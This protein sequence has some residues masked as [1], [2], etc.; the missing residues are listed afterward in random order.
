M[1]VYVI[2]PF[3][4]GL[5]VMGLVLTLGLTM[6]SQ[7]IFKSLPT[8]APGPI[9]G[10]QTNER[11]MALT[12]NV[13]WGGEVIPGML[14]VLKKEN[15]K[16]TFFVSGR[17]AKNNPELLKTMAAEGHQIEN[18]GYSHPHP[19]RISVDE[20]KREI[21][22]T[23]QVIEGLTGKKTTFFAPPYGEKGA[24][25]LRAANELKYITTLWTLDTVDWR[26]DSTVEL[27]VQRVVYPQVKLG[28]KPEKKG[29]IVLMHPKPN[30]VKALPV[31][32]T[33]L[34]QEGFRFVSISQ[35]M[36]SRKN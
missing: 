12:I 35:L 17:W 30:T 16:A 23:E 28:V 6:G 3:Q 34:K 20:N 22:R 27:I 7:R 10:I 24:S 5:I 25:G 1:R 14:E 36:E 11:V 9:S 29:A 8:T 2:R 15:V 33:S 4:I 31:I 26:E 21:L 18:H 13:D 32:I 19:D